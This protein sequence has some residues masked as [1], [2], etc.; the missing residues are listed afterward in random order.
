MSD[1]NISMDQANAWVAKVEKEFEECKKIL[2]DA[3]GVI[4]ECEDD[5]D[6][7]YQHLTKAEKEFENAWDRL[8]KGYDEVINRLLGGFRKSIEAMENAIE[9][10]Q[11]V[12][13]RPKS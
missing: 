8:A 2:R 7:I 10:V 3:R 11:D 1:L 9:W 5:D 13:K 12:A 6:T 4:K